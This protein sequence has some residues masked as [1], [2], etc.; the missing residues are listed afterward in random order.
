MPASVC[1]LAITHDRVAN[2][3]SSLFP[4]ASNREKSELVASRVSVEGQASFRRER[5]SP[6]VLRRQAGPETGGPSRLPRRNS[7]HLRR[8]NTTHI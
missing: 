1:R 6:S 4:R 8:W 5:S 7:Y 3:G 2:V